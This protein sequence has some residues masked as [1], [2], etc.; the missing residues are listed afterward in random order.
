MTPVRH[1]STA[2]SALACAAL[3]AG[4]A[5]AINASAATAGAPE[6]TQLVHVKAPTAA[7]RSAVVNL[8]VDATEHADST[9][10]DVLLHSA[11]D[12]KVL[13]EAGFTWTVRNA[14]LGASTAAA[15]RADRAY[16]KAKVKSP[17]PSG[18]T[19]YRTYANYGAEMAKLAQQYPERV[20]LITLKNRTKQGRV[21]QG[22][23]I[24][25]DVTNVND[26]KPVFL[27]MGLHHA[28]EWPSG[29]HS[30]EYA[31]DLLQNVTG[32]SR[33]SRILAGT[34]TIIVPVVNPDGFAIS[35]NAVV[36]GNDLAYEYKRKNCTISVLTPVEFTQGGCA[37][38]AA[39][40]NRGTDLNRNY[41][42]FWG[43]GGA[44]P[45]WRSETFRGDGPGSEPETD[46]IRTLISQRQVTN[47][48]SNHTYSNLVLRAPSIAATGFSPDEVAY[49][50]LG[51]TMAETNGY[52]SQASFQLYD[53]SGS[54]E[55]WSYWNTGG[56]GFTF[57]IGNQNF[58]PEFENA[59]VGEYLGLAPAA[60]AGKGGNREAYY[61]MSEATLDASQH[62]TITGS[63][64][65]GHTLQVAKSF[66]TAT[67]PVIGVDG[68]VG[69]PL[70]Y[71]D[72]L[73]SRLDTTGEAFTWAVNPSTRPL[74]TG[75][76]G[77]DPEGPTQPTITAVNP[78][79]IPAEGEDESFTFT[80]EGMPTY[81]NAK[82]E[83]RV[84]WDDS[85][86]DWD[87][88]VYDAAGNEV[89]SAASLDDPEIAVLVDPVPGD[90]TVVVQNYDGGDTSDWTGE[91]R[92]IAPTPAIVTGVTEN[93]NLSCRDA[94]GTI[95]GR[96][97][98]LVKR[99]ESVDVGDPC[100][101]RSK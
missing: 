66:V 1:R 64:P 41:P 98:V 51:D 30:M 11:K 84:G 25:D 34:R 55:D 68:T 8:P 32:D 76:Y 35:R 80:I 22:M 7:K 4:S 16:A 101:P 73:A 77:R 45:N 56:L 63:A 70:Y 10:I 65:E 94:D 72:R 27:M 62:S 13:R 71:A 92:F 23:E 39:G 2:V 93:Y 52:T 95:V 81:D 78:D 88:F 3:L 31:Y 54:V 46:N 38:N 90:Y 96:R 58:H 42:G 79:G 57:E 19:T 21:V 61:R 47:L 89:A 100:T 83:V 5:L 33:A 59:V 91:V 60:G 29:E 36:P 75:R 12:A 74:V 14:D 18:R 82:A 87:V 99:G 48:I 9:G 15:V 28:R 97:Q 6:K 85:D 53:T 43:G 40:A 67:S 26:G 86:V 50:A 44:S 24:T 20:K 37:N 17:L 69:P 49:K